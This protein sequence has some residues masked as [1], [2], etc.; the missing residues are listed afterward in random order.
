MH[1]FSFQCAQSSI[2]VQSSVHSIME[3]L[4][5]LG[6]K[7]VVGY[8]EYTGAH[9]G[10]SLHCKARRCRTRAAGLTLPDDDDDFETVGQN[11]GGKEGLHCVCNP[12]GITLGRQVASARARAVVSRAGAGF[13][14][15]LRLSFRGAFL[16]SRAD[17]A[18]AAPRLAAK[19]GWPWGWEGAG[20][21]SQ[22][23]SGVRAEPLGGARNSPPAKPT[24][25]PYSY[26]RSG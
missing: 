12:G 4:C 25:G 5:T 21:V 8:N 6:A 17:G 14:S 23:P 19:T 3:A 16:V 11:P 18:A 7:L 9:W 24:G 10:P 1:A 13:E 20:S 15:E 22:R 26:E 2:I